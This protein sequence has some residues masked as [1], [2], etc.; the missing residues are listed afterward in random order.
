MQVMS[1]IKSWLKMF[2][3]TIAIVEKEKL[4][5]LEKMDKKWAD[6]LVS[7]NYLEAKLVHKMTQK[8]S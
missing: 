2:K 6:Q 3:V 1:N 8:V 4:F 5:I 7:R